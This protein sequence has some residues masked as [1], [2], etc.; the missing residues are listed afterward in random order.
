MREWRREVPPVS[1]DVKD[2]TEDGGAHVVVARI[3]GE[4][5]GS[6]VGLRFAFRFDGGGKIT[7]STIRP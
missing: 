3:S 1:Y 2:V 4:F 5:S 6:P 7:S